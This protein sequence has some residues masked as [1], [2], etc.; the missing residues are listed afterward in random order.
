MTTT[1]WE[2]VHQVSPMIVMGDIKPWGGY[3]VCDILEDVRVE[4]ITLNM[5]ATFDSA[6]LVYN[7][8]VFGEEQPYFKPI[9]IIAIEGAGIKAKKSVLFRGFIAQNK[10]VIDPDQERMRI[11][12][13]DYKWLMARRTMI[14]GQW[15]AVDVANSAPSSL[16]SGLSIGGAKLTYEKFRARPQNDGGYLQ[17]RPCV[18]NQNGRPD[19]FTRSYASSMC[20]FYYPE[21]NWKEEEGLRDDYWENLTWDGHFWTWATIL[22]HIEKFWIEPYN[23]SLTNV[24]IHRRD[25]SK[26]AAIDD[27]LSKPIDFS[28][29]NMNPMN[30]L[31]NVV[32]N[33]PGRWFWYLDYS[34]PTVKI[35]IKEFDPNRSANDM[36]LR[37]CD[38]GEKIANSNAN[39]ERCSV[40][41]D[42]AD[43]SKY[44]IAKGG[45]LKIVT[46]VKLVPLWKRYGDKKDQDFE[47]ADDL[48]AWKNYLGLKKVDK[49]E[50]KLD[51]ATKLR[52]DRIYRYY[53]IPLEGE[54]LGRQIMTEEASVLDV[55][56]D[57]T[58]PTI[59][60]S[61]TIGREYSVY[62]RD[63]RQ[64]FFQTGWM[65][66]EISAPNFAKYTDQLCLFMWDDYHDLIFYDANGAEIKSKKRV[67][68][69]VPPTDTEFTQAK[70]AAQWII[71]TKDKFGYQLDEKN[72]TI[73]FDKP[74]FMRETLPS[75]EDSEE[76]DA[77]AAKYTHDG[78][79][80]SG[81]KMQAREV[82]LTATFT[83]DAQHC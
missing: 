76:M 42:G 64:L 79:G 81:R 54:L 49:T 13:H 39:L 44:A 69:G 27:S 25:L 33:L 20:V 57:L 78:S 77:A 48:K 38:A 7:D 12:C 72:G 73:V 74:Q 66:R 23:A 61:G 46:T 21:I 11:V 60:L 15:Y 67:L 9:Q 18:F 5:G 82:Y 43:A 35:R 62:E 19:C 59:R 8:K 2:N 16:G 22:S 71:P 37:I 47:D 14:R 6:T 34:Q 32:R 40:T 65:H 55:Q 70:N 26:I 68:D 58:Q 56:Q 53:G 63:I 51:A 83:L 29:E 41:R 24:R 3:S 52:Y 45:K 31:D 1:F 75:D 4:N 36:Y 50:S 10:G 30:A 17:N 80:T 28:L